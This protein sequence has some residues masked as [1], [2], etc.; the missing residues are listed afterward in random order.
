MNFGKKML[1]K[2]KSELSFDGQTT[3]IDRWKSYSKLKKWRR[4]LSSPMC[5]QNC[6]Y[7]R[8]LVM[9]KTF[10]FI[11]IM[12]RYEARKETYDIINPTHPPK[13]FLILESFVSSRFATLKNTISMLW[14]YILRLKTSPWNDLENV[15]KM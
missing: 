11:G 15:S 10:H 1:Y 7:W 8:H 13:P 9:K 2:N 14:Y 12:K 6:W 3:L 4:K 5:N